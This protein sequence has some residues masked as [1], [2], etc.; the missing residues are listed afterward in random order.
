[1]NL[2]PEMQKIVDA[3]KDYRRSSSLVIN[4]AYARSEVVNG[5]KQN[6][7]KLVEILNRIN[8]IIDSKKKKF[9]LDALG[10]SL[11]FDSSRGGKTRKR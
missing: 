4:S 3:L 9:E 7:G 1:M 2:I 10:D 11:R 6:D 8:R 5:L